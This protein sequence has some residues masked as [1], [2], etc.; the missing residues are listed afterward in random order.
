ML[1]LKTVCS[2]GIGIQK[3]AAGLAPLVG[4]AS[5]L[6]VSVDKHDIEEYAI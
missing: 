1:R 3:L 6:L 2:A 5:G 4:S